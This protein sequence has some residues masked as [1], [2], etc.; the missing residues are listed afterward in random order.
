MFLQL[1]LTYQVMSLNP[2][3]LDAEDTLI[4]EDQLNVKVGQNVD[5]PEQEL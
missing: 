4:N 2:V 5:G 1:V 3:N